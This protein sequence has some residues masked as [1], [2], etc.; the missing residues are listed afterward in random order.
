MATCGKNLYWFTWADENDPPHLFLK[1]G[2][3]SRV[4]Y[5]VLWLFKTKKYWISEDQ[6][7]ISFPFCKWNLTAFVWNL[8]GCVEKLLNE[9]YA[10]QVNEYLFIVQ[11]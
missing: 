2:T 1:L 9:N 5:A 3:D 8:A 6:S 11:V 10:Y 4:L 7:K